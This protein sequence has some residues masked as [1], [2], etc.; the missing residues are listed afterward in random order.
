MG[1][2]QNFLEIKRVLCSFSKNLYIKKKKKKEEGVF[3]KYPTQTS[4][5]C[6]SERATKKKKFFKAK[7]QEFTHRR[8]PE[9]K[10]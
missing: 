10:F 9:K 1:F 6:P 8:T 4:T 3:T 7:A 5:V 2:T